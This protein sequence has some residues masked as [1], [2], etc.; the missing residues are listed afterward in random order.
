[1]LHE[2]HKTETCSLKTFA[3]LLCTALMKCSDLALVRT[4]KA[5]SAILVRADYGSDLW[6]GGIENWDRLTGMRATKST[7]KF[8]GKK[9]EYVSDE[10]FA[11][12]KQALEEAL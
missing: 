5:C 10:A 1:M 4:C 6:P 11:G 7:H 2:Y 3:L 12:L 9:T 8:Q